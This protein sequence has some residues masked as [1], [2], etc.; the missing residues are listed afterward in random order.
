M[1]DNQ[2]F[3]MVPD[4][5]KH[6]PHQPNH[7]SHLESLGGHFEQ[8]WAVFSGFWGVL[9]GLGGPNA[10]W[11][12]RALIHIFFSFCLPLVTKDFMDCPTGSWPSWA[13][14]LSLSS[15][16]DSPFMFA[17]K[18][19]MKVSLLGFVSYPT[20]TVSSKRIDYV[21]CILAYKCLMNTS[22]ICRWVGIRKSSLMWTAWLAALY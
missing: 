22:Q 13:W 17:E 7:K 15:S 5:A 19:K 12:H 21:I 18:E 10:Q 20:Q 4:Q 16:W 3:M 1:G 6:L 9:R 8:F 14:S 2:D 11:G